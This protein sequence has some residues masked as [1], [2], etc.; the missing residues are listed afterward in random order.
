MFTGWR[1]RVSA[2]AIV[3]ARGGSKRIKNKNIIDFFGRPM[4]AYSLEAARSA[5]IFDEI[6][7]STESE[8]IRAVVVSLGFPVPFL[9]DPA[10]ADDKTALI[11]VLRW[12]LH[13]Y[14]EGGTRF[15]DVCLLMA[16]TPLIDASDLRRA[17]EAYRHGGGRPLLAVSKYPAPVERAFERDAQG[18]LRARQ[19]AAMSAHS[20]DLAETYFDAGMFAIM[21]AEH[22]LEMRDAGT[23]AWTSYVLPR[24]RGVDINDDED[25]ELARIIYLGMRAASSNPKSSSER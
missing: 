14:A 13:R 2:I 11:P 9:R 25:L 21:P 23:T 3:P 24:S 12:V 16:T 19:P 7:V 6:H 15:D 20:Q 17:Y 8:A 1:C 5:G 18:L 22:V 10:L 4:I